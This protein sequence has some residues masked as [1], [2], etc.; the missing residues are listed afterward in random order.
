MFPSVKLRMIIG[1]VAGVIFLLLSA[2]AMVTTFEG[3]LMNNERN[4]KNP[5]R[6]HF[7]VVK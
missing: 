4:P 7:N 5:E 2:M 6:L 1:N 3:F